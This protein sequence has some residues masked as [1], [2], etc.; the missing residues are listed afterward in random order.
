MSAPTAAYGGEPSDG[1]QTPGTGLFRELARTVV[2]VA[3]VQ[4]LRSF[5]LPYPGIAQRALDRTVTHCLDIGQTPPRSL[6]ELWEWC[7]SRTAADPLFGVPASFVAPDATLVHP[8][9]RMPTRICLEVASHGPIGGVA[10]EAR[11]HLDA[12]EARC[13]SDERFR[14]CRQFLARNPVV[15]L[16][17]RFGARRRK[18]G[19]NQ[20]AWTRVKELYRPVPES[21]YAGGVALRCPTC[22]LPALTHDRTVP[23]PGRP[24]AAGQTWCE[25]EECAR[26][27]GLELIRKPKL[28]LVQPRSLRVFLALPHPAEEAALSGLDAAGIGWEPVPGDLSAYRLRE[29]GG[30]TVDVRIRDRQEPGL[31]AAGLAHPAPSADRTFVVVPQ[32]LADRAGYRARFTAAL[33]APLRERLA[34]TTPTG[35]VPGIRGED[36]HDA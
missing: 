6:P 26:D 25:A 13:G 10:A 18:A 34:L 16:E 32:R 9:G 17:D 1:P 30:A 2:A 22:G 31:L 14:L 12:L 15:Y 24:L 27:N 8:V 36:Q 19:W 11:T 28:A 5:T 23:L 20:E 33:P 3:E 7:R 21:L 29:T 4:G 35:L